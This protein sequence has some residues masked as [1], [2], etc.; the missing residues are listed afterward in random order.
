M[1]TSALLARTRVLL[2][3]VLLACA[4][5]GTSVARTA[6]QSTPGS[7]QGFQPLV[8]GDP[9]AGE[10]E[11]F[12]PGSSYD[13]AI[14]EPDEV[15][16][17]ALGTRMASHEE[18]LAI[19]RG[20]DQQSP[21][22]ALESYGRTHEG[23]ELVVGIVTS[24]ANHDRM[25]GILSAIQ[26]LADPRGLTPAEEEA[27]LAETPAI[28]WMGYS[29]HGDETS[30]VDGGLG[31]AYHL[32]AAQGDEIEHLLDE[33]VVV[34]DP[35]MNPDGRERYRA[36]MLQSAGAVPSLDADSL[37]RGRWPWG[38][39]NHYLFDMNRDWMVG[40]APETRGR[41][42]VLRRFPPQLFVDAHE[43]GALDTYLFYPQ[44]QP[45]NP[46]LPESL[47]RWHK[48]FA[49]AQGAAFD[50]RGW[51]Y[52]TRE[53]ADG[54]GPYYSDAWGALN[55][56]V[57]MLYEQ[58]GYGGQPLRRASGEVVTYRESAWHQAVASLASLSTLVQHRQEVLR[59]FVA[60]RR[61][62]LALDAP[63]R[64]RAFVLIPG[65]HPSRERWLI[66]TLL[67]QGVELER[68]SA[69][70]TVRNAHSALGEERAEL[71][72]PAGAI[73]VPPSQ[74]LSSLTRSYLAFD[75]RID[76]A[77][78]REEREELERKGRS[79][80]YDHT[81]WC[82][83]HALDLD[84]W[85]CDPPARSEGGQEA[86]EAVEAP[87]SGL[88]PAQDPQAPVY[89]WIVDGTDDTALAFAA[90]ALELGLAVQL[91]D[92]PFESAG[93]TFARGSLLVRRHENQPDVAQ[94]VERA[95]RAS[96]ALAWPTAGARAPADGPDLGGQHFRLLARPRVA[97]LAGSPVSVSEFGHLWHLLDREL[98]VP[99]SLLEAT[100]LSSYD[101][102]RY[103]VLVI[104]PA[105]GNL[106]ALLAPLK[107]DLQAWVRSGGTLIAV[108]SAARTLAD[109]EL[110][111]ST[112]REL[113][114][115]LDE[116]A[117]YREAAQREWASRRIEVDPAAVWGGPQDGQEAEAE[118]PEEGRASGDKDR[119]EEAQRED[120]WRRRFMPRGATLLGLC[121]DQAW[122]T[123]GCG[124]RLPVLSD[125][126]HVLMARSPA[127]TAVRLA[128][129]GELRLAGLLWPEARELLAESAWLTVE[130]LGHGQVILF[131]AQPAFR[132]FHKASGRLFA[133]AVVYGPGAGADQPLGW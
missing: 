97:L 36:M 65:R 12:F 119:G 55:G 72:L 132:G 7:A 43:M 31:F 8:I 10:L 82:L 19:W 32:I 102:R 109:K 131:A 63:E 123:A 133:N 21:R 80:L 41:W 6:P 86:L 52:Y 56:A 73:V 22:V 44:S 93:R 51:S 124:E 70:V 34:I 40:V 24:P 23:R 54:W 130:R 98:G 61:A 88:A 120:R 113:S 13:G 114:D 26:R 27:L 101:L 76:D 77:T 60:F 91:A 112:V 81:A 75:L 129:A 64:S 50:Q 104:P 74:P 49:D 89:G 117:A 84:A 78:L 35:C 59:D 67:A 96:G 58:A 3:L 20:W 69:A 115:V 106:R 5:P 100:A 48:V 17:R 85:W 2:P 18:V 92:K 110:G 1:R 37:S 46:H 9:P 103:N 42:S 118:P 11:P 25:K 79:S 108:D 121:D 128:P 66:E 95:A 45:H 127:R 111:L 122:I 90:R 28:A 38:R 125:G 68:R 29:I 4:A 94:S 107:D 15:L 105:G 116:R 87:Q 57:G 33:T 126:E 16:G 47:K 71:E 39:G 62:N 30:G 99:V 14:L 53:W 83:V